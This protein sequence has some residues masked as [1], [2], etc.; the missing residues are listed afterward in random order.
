MISTNEDSFDTERERRISHW[1]ISFADSSSLILDGD[2]RRIMPLL[3][4]VSMVYPSDLSEL[5]NSLSLDF[6]M[7]VSAMIASLDSSSFAWLFKY[8]ISLFFES[9]FSFMTFIFRKQGKLR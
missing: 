3:F 8:S 6:E 9:F 1:R 7:P 5:I 4:G 2:T